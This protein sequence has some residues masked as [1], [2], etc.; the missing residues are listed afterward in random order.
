MGAAT[1]Q[2]RIA[3]G[4]QALA[5]TPSRD[6][7]MGVWAAAQRVIAAVGLAATA[8]AL[9]AIGGAVAALSRR[10]PLVAH[11]RVG[12]DGRP[13]WM[14]KFRTMWGGGDGAKERTCCGGLVAYLEAQEHS[15]A[16]IKDGDDPRVTSRL[17]RFLRKHSLDEAPQLIHVIAGEMALVGPRP[18]LR[19]ELSAY[20]GDDAEEVLRAL[21]GLTGLWQV[22]GRS[23]LSYAQRRRLDL[24]LVR[25]HSVGL[26]WWILGRTVPQVVRGANAW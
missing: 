19:P 15:T 26:H 18:L 13:F 5:K 3:S 6:W 21:P 9:V 8:P 12:K 10:S 20:Y 25:H 23:R 14:L 11:R 2:I 16:A 7:A 4:P 17:A 24:F 22:M 1:G